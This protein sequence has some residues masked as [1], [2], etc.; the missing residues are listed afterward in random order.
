M[1]TSEEAIEQLIK[2]FEGVRLKAYPDPGSGGDPW[3]IGYGHTSGVRKNDTCTLE[4]A[5]RMLRDIDIPVAEAAVNRFVIHSITQ[6]QFDALVSFVFNLGETKFRGSTLLG[7]LNQ[8]NWKKAALEFN[9]WKYAGGKILKGLVLRR[10][11]ETDWF[12]KGK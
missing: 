8:G 12:N 9:K 5:D 7:L 10:Q 11:A 3:T 4:Q 6:N 1:K 2:Y